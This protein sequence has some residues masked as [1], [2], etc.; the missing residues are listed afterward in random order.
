MND[1]E[2]RAAV[3]AELG[4]IERPA[5]EGL[6]ELYGVGVQRCSLPLLCRRLLGHLGELPERLYKIIGSRLGH[7]H[8]ARRPVARP[9]PIAL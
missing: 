6:A 1:I 8:L 2:K 5:A 3:K 9:S 4:A 7:V